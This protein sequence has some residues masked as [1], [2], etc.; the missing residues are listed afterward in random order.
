MTPYTFD[1]WEFIAALLLLALFIGGPLVMF[2]LDEDQPPEPTTR[3]AA[4][5]LDYG[6]DERAR[7]AGL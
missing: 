3:A 1:A 4:P 2:N 7:R 6:P 5:D